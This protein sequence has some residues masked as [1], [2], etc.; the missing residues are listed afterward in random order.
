MKLYHIVYCSSVVYYSFINNTATVALPWGSYASRYGTWLLLLSRCL[1]YHLMHHGCHCHSFNTINDPWLMLSGSQ[2]GRG[3]GEQHYQAGRLRALV[4]GEEAAA[5]SYPI[6]TA[7]TRLLT[8]AIKVCSPITLLHTAFLYTCSKRMEYED[9]LLCSLMHKLL[10]Y[11]VVWL[12][13]V[14]VVEWCS[15]QERW[16]VRCY[17]GASSHRKSETQS[18]MPHWHHYTTLFSTPLLVC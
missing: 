4:C 9:A 10:I 18:S 17:D 16:Q 15:L 11:R 5:G 2:Q 3:G 12:V 13:Q 7:Y 6:L 14:Y 1:Q 8:A